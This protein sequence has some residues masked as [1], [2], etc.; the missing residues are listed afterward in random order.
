MSPPYLRAFRFRCAMSA[1]SASVVSLAYIVF[2]RLSLSDTPLF[3][4][5]IELV[6]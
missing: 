5:Y 6:W 1:H 2:R 3:L 4:A